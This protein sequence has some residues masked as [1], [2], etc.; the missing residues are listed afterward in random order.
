MTV[1]ELIDLLEQV[2]DLGYG[3]FEVKLDCQKRTNPL[4]EV[5][6]RTLTEEVWLT[7]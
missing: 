7:D 6:Y 5:K 4:N 2:D 3:D 1:R